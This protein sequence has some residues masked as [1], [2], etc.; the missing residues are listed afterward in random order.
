MSRLAEAAITL[1]ARRWPPR[2]RDEWLAEMAAMSGERERLAFAAGLLVSPSADGMRG[3]TVAVAGGVTLLAAALANAVHATSQ[4]MMIAAAGVMVL[5]G[6]RLRMSAP[7]AVALL[8]PALFAF[9][10]IGNDIAV[11]PFMGLV[12]VGPAAAVWTAG[13]L[14]TVRFLDKP[15]ALLAGALGT[16]SAATAAGSVHAAAELGVSFWSAPAWFP[17]ALL[18]PSPSAGIPGVLLGNA[19]AMTAP[20]LLCAVFVVALAVRAPAAPDAAL[21]SPRWRVPAALVAA[22]LAVV[23]CQVTTAAGTD[24]STTMQ[25][26]LDHSAVFGFGFAGGVPGQAAVALIAAV[27]ALRL[28]EPA[29]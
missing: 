11:M 22:P 18:P 29:A 16:M 24:V 9:L 6:M 20:M 2:M 26:L 12:D 8:G 1:A 19:T 4:P 27:L 13:M 7:A 14:A 5:A 21:R 3:G 10:L 23:V 17:L 28:V 25:R 15:V